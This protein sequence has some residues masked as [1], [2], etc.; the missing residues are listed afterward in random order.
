[1]PTTTKGLPYPLSTAA[2]N[3]PLD[4]QALAGALDFTRVMSLTAV[5]IPGP[6]SLIQS[7]PSGL[8]L[9]S[10]SGSEASAGGWP[11]AASCH[12]LTIKTTSARAAQILFTNSTATTGIRAYYR[13]MNDTSNS[14]WAGGSGT[15]SEAVGQN[16]LDGATGNPTAPV[17]VTFPTGRF[18][19]TPR[20]LLASQTPSWVAGI[21]A[22]SATSFTMLA[23]NV[24]AFASSFAVAWHAIQAYDTTSDG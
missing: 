1:M 17:V 24:S 2:P 15:Y 7:Y 4:I 13:Q 14:A 22:I 23:R 8:S 9:L 12:V 19:R 16:N 21:S 11:G 5:D 6:F 20:L 18:T 10:L 3:V